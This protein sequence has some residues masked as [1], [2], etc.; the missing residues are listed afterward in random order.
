V[1]TSERIVESQK[2][3]RSQ[4]GQTSDRKDDEWMI[5]KVIVSM[6]LFKHKM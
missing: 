6:G 5:G 2:Q 4:V 1:N 3:I